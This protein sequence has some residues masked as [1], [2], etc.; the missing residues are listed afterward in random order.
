VQF[1]VWLLASLEVQ[2]NLN[3]GIS[4]EPDI[5]SNSDALQV[6]AQHSQFIS[7]P[8]HPFPSLNAQPI[9]PESL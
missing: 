9:V 5:I 1:T 7:F 6:S 2:R 4:V 3:K 8:L